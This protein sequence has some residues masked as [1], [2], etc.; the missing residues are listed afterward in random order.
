M[1]THTCTQV[2]THKHTHTH[3]HPIGKFPDLYYFL[4]GQPRMG[5][6]ETKDESCIKVLWGGG[7]YGKVN[8]LIFFS[9]ELCHTLG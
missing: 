2:P 9:K 8:H 6:K 5:T 4:L 1:G 3:T 7:R